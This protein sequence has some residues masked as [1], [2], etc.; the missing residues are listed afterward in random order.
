VSGQLPEE[1][2]LDLKLFISVAAIVTVTGVGGLDTSS[3]LAQITVPTVN[4]CNPGNAP[5]PATGFRSVACTYS[6][7]TT[8]VTNAQ[9]A[10]FLNSVPD[11]AHDP[12]IQV[13]A[14]A[15]WGGRWW[16]AG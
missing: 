13:A 5:D 1:S 15:A 12:L 8:E 4:T 3:A 7:A 6:I 14:A 10:A 2:G 16:W 11:P 9:Y